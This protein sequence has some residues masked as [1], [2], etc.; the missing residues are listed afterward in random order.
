MP[1]YRLSRRQ[2]HDLHLAVLDDFRHVSLA[3]FMPVI[4]HITNLNLHSFARCS[5]MHLSPLFSSKEIDLARSCSGLFFYR[6]G[7]T[8]LCLLTRQIEDR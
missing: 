8:Q 2:Y 1:G 7:C 4:A 5:I 6:V 3:S